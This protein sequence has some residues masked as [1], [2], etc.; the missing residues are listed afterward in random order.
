MIRSYNSYVQTPTVRPCKI[1]NEHRS[2]RTGWQVER[3]ARQSKDQLS[4]GEILEAAARVRRSRLPS[5][6]TRAVTE[7]PQRSVKETVTNWM[8]SCDVSGIS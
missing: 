5:R 4:N 3:L 7:E 6:K 2:T 8:K 1:R